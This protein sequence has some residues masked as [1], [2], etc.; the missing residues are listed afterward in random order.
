MPNLCENHT[1]IFGPKE[2]IERLFAV[3]DIPNAEQ[4]LT[5]L[6]PMP[7]DIADENIREWRIANWGNK[8]GDYDYFTD[9]IHVED[10]EDG[11]A[12]ISLSYHTAWSPFDKNYW[13]KVSFQWPTLWF[14]TSYSE[15]GMCFVGAFSARNGAVKNIE[16]TDL[17]DWSGLSEDYSDWLDAIDQLRNE[18][19]DLVDERTH[20]G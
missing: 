12:S 19:A 18:C 4:P 9:D 15:P 7:I 17:P 11:T 1:S 13:T 6:Y 14:T 16:T 3:L 5:N 10:Y 20:K 8:W 2:D